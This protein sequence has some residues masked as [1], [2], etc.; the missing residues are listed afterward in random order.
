MTGASAA[1]ALWGIIGQIDG[2]EG[3]A[4]PSPMPHAVTEEA[5]LAIGEPWR[6]LGEGQILRIGVHRG[7]EGRDVICRAKCGGK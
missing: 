2:G 6:C 3:G 5:L 4:V 1:V 7:V